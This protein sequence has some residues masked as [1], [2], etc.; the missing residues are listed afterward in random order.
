MFENT[1]KEHAESINA[2][3]LSVLQHIIVA[4]PCRAGMARHVLI[5]SKLRVIENMPERIYFRDAN[6]C[7]QATAV[8]HKREVQNGHRF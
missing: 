7:L 1:K 5:V 8:Q 6:F 3:T 2:P 4:Q